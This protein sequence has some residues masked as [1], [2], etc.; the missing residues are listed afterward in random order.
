MNRV[1]APRP[2]PPP[3]FVN[4]D[5]TNLVRMM[6]SFME[7]KEEQNTSIVQQNTM[8]LQQLEAARVSEETSQCQYMA[9]MQ[10]L[11]ETKTT[12]GSSHPP[13][14]QTQEWRL[15]NFL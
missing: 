2:P 10:Q 9:T 6:E 1:L 13:P 14:I 11:N 8:A 5:V 12:V 4:Q 3:P 7:T 15:E